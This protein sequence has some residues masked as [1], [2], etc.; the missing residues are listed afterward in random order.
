MDTFLVAKMEKL[1]VDKLV[2]LWLSPAGKAAVQEVFE[3]KEKF[4]AYV[5]SV[6]QLGVWLRLPS[7]K[8]STDRTLDSLLLL[9]WE[10]LATAQVGT[11]TGEILPEDEKRERI[12]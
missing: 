4:K 1:L 5:Q 8:G 7:K 2:S 10:Y 6:D 12:Q 9:K 3:G 11:G